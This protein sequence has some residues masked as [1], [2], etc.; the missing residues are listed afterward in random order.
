MRTIRLPRLAFTRAALRSPLRLALTGLA[1]ATMSTVAKAQDSAQARP[2]GLPKGVEWTF[3]LDAGIG[4][5]GFANSLYTNVRPDPSGDL[6]DNWAESYVKPALTGTVGLGKS[7]LYAG[8]SAVGERTFAAPPPL[9]GV[10]AAS[11][12]PEDLYIGWRSGTSVGKA[13]DLLDLS[14]GRQKFTIGHGMLLWDGAAEGG[15]RGG[16]WSNARKAWAFAGLAR[17]TQKVHHLTA[18]YV[19]RN[20]IPEFDENARAFGANYDLVLNEQSTFGASWFQTLSDSVPDRDGQN[21]FNLRA[22]TAPLRSIPDLAFEAEYAYETNGSLV[23]SNAWTVQVGYTLSKAAWT[24]TFSY[25]YAFFQGDDPATAENEAFDPLFPGFY[26]WGTWWQGEIAGEYFVANSNLVTNQLRVSLVPSDRL[27]TGLIAYYFQFDQ[28]GAVGPG[29]TS[30]DI[31]GEIDAYADWK[32]NSN[33]TISVVAAFANPGA[34]VAQAY[35]RTENFVYG[36]LFVA[37]AY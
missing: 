19:D 34:G 5:F 15:S 33:F 27:G 3:N 22:Y 28:P 20:G 17:V 37:Y 16:F 7:T 35:D 30:K 26:D 6:S 1:L 12:G 31:A 2:T 18:F 9:V 11:F 4:G 36:M 13:T 24:P 21:V 25:R 14:V 32:A 23:S 29:V 10:E 8:L